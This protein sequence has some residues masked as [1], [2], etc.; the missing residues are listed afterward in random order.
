MLS[1]IATGELLPDPNNRKYFDVSAKISIMLILAV[2]AFF[3]FFAFTPIDGTSMEKTIYDKHYCMVQRKCF[4]VERGDIVTV[5]ISDTKD[6]HIVVKRIIAVGGDKLL[7]MKSKDGKSYDLYI[8]YS[9]DKHLKLLNENYINEKMKVGLSVY[10]GTPLM[11]YQEHVENVDL[12]DESNP[13]T[14]IVNEKLITVPDGHI[15][16]LGDNRNV[17]KDSR[18]YG[19]QSLDKVTSKVVWII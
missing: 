17:S 3:Y 14:A 7:F 11:S 5:N 18:F 13:R 6:K 19:T 10:Y 9:G 12:T 8:C 4:D 15:Y 16:F 1:E 2:I